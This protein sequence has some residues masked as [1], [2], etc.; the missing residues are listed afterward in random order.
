[1]ADSKK[2]LEETQLS[3]TEAKE[4][5]LQFTHQKQEPIVQRQIRV[6][7]E[8]VTNVTDKE[9]Q[10]PVVSDADSSDSD[11]ENSSSS[12]EDK[13]KPIVIP[14]FITTQLVNI[15]TFRV[16]KKIS[17]TKKFLKNY[18]KKWIVSWLSGKKP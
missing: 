5:I 11:E 3:L 8:P 18:S 1:M 12:D 6:L 4:T 2:N 7:P 15:C 13:V 10:D 16:G 14:K 9:T 17:S